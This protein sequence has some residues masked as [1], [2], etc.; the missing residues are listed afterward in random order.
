MIN[1]KD[2]FDK[3]NFATHLSDKSP[4]SNLN[5]LGFLREMTIFNSELSRT[6]SI[7]EDFKKYNSVDITD[8]RLKGI[9]PV[10]DNYFHYFSDF[11]GPVILFLDDCV[12]NNVESVHFI[13]THY[14]NLKVINNFD[15]FLDYSLSKYANLLNVSYQVVDFSQVK[16]I[17]TNNVVMLRQADIGESIYQIYKDITEFAGVDLTV[18][19]NVKAFLT[20]NKDKNRDGS[21]NRTVNEE[22][23]E[24]FFRSQGFEIIYGEMFNS[25]E[26]QVKYFNSVSVFAGLTGSGLTSA[27]FMQKRQTVIEVVTPMRFG[28]YTDKYE[29]HNFYKTICMLKDHKLINI[30]NINKSSDRVIEDLSKAIK[31]LDL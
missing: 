1:I 8:K 23:C 2:I 18:K 12:K 25:L 16:Y 27:M 31:M 14:G 6:H 29:L 22:E 19:P 17:K 13:F 20:R 15:G 10:T 11:I 21:F 9:M 7:P 24:D 3:H 26:E 4:Y 28:G 30:G 5:T